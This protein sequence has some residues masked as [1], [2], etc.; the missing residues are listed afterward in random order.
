MIKKENLKD[1]YPLSAMQEGMLFQSLLNPEQTI[2]HEQ[3]SYRLEG[4]IDPAVIEKTWQSLFLRH[5]ILRTVFISEKVKRPLQAVLHNLSGGFCY[6]D[7]SDQN[8]DTIEPTIAQALAD[9]K[10][11]GFDLKSGPLMR[12]TLIKHSQDKYTLIWSHHHILMDGWCIG[13][14]LGDFM[15]LYQAH[16][17]NTANTLA[18]PPRYS[19]Y[20]KWLELADRQQAKSYW[21]TKLQTQTQLTT[22]TQQ[23]DDTTDTIG[24]AKNEIITTLPASLCQNIY[25]I[26]NQWQVTVGSLM[27]AAWAA[28]LSHY[29]D[30]EEIAFATLV[31]GRPGELDG[32]LEMLG[33]FI[34]TIPLALT[35]GP[36][37][38]LLSLARKIQNDLLESEPHQHLPLSDIQQ[39]SPLGKDLIKHIFAFENFPE[40]Q[41]NDYFKVTA[42]AKKT[43]I[44]YDFGLMVVPNTAENTAQPSLNLH[45]LYDTKNF[46]DRFINVL[47]EQFTTILTQGLDGERLQTVALISATEYEQ[48]KQFKGKQEALP[49]CQ[50]YIELFNQAV[51][52]FPDNIAVQED[53]NSVTYQELDRLA[54][55]M[56]ALLE[57][58]Y[59]VQR[60]ERIA[61]VLSR[62]ISL[63]VSQ[64]ACSKLGAIF[65]PC[66]PS[67]PTQRLTQTIQ[68]SQP[69]LVLSEKNAVEALQTTIDTPVVTVGDIQQLLQP[70]FDIV[71]NADQSKRTYR[72]NDL[73]YIIF[74]SGSTGTPKGVMIEHLG[75]INLIHWC[76]TSFK[77]NQNT[78]AS[79]IASPAFDASILE[80]FPALCAGATLHIIP[81]TATKNTQAMAE[82]I[83]EKKINHSFLPPSMCEEACK[84]YSELI[85]HATIIVGG[86][87]LNTIHQSPATVYNNYGPTEFSVAATS[88][89]ITP[90]DVSP[91]SI[92]SVIPNNEVLILNSRR[93]LCPIGVPGEIA[94]AGLSIA[95][96]YWN[97]AD[98]SSQRF[99]E[100]PFEAGQRMYL[101]GDKGC[102]REDGKLDFLGRMDDQIS[103]RGHRIEPTEIEKNL[104]T[105]TSVS[106]AC[107]VLSSTLEQSIDQA[108]VLVAFVV[109]TSMSQTEDDRLSKDLRRWLATRLPHYMIPSIFIEIEKMPLNNNGKIDRKRVRKI[110]VPHNDS[111]APCLPTTETEKQVIEIWQQVLELENIGIYDNF[112]EIGGHSLSATRVMS[113]IQG[114]YA[115]Q[116]PL[117]L[118]FE[119]P[120][121]N[122]FAAHI[123]QL[124]VQATQST[125]P[126]ASRSKIT[127]IDRSKH[128]VRS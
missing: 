20:I 98:T 84:Y 71:D 62:S 44:P 46:S 117:S 77:L 92:G 113:Q 67:H 65:V 63:I 9:D 102:W 83:H 74:T 40:A 90:D 116:I 17:N 70:F 6:L 68:R 11:R 72:I 49:D 120:V 32:A 93:Q 126:E 121:L 80:I 59:Q 38:T 128:R 26:A 94:L 16:K 57:T 105:H 45:L 48:F 14:I 41:S 15:A 99:V 47:I 114:I 79:V 82:I 100:H 103:L 25:D 91:Y 51:T 31:S 118:A 97:D 95:R 13:I 35:V 10:A 112:L 8:I 108:D 18:P 56:A 30:R 29:N 104:L 2:Y 5:D 28:L 109:N 124:R 96:G 54:N 34:N 127:R 3:V 61:L 42:D 69:T 39:C 73:A 24:R 19:N 53:Q 21:Q 50:S 4:D 64:L 123:D 37:D 119:K 52:N 111:H 86:D 60:G 88:T 85:S 122:E 43:E 55:A 115:I 23:H 12:L 33:V 66:D 101:T 7:L 58:Q 27:Q 75:L 76:Q 36:E 106:H 87:V 1:L 107:V 125:T 110:A 89:L 81:A 22:L 78:H